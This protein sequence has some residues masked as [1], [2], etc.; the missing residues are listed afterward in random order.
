[1]ASRRAAVATANVLCGRLQLERSMWLPLLLNKLPWL[2]A[3]C[4]QYGFPGKTPPITG[5][6]ADSKYSSGV[7]GPM[8][9]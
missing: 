2:L 7:P 9:F 3:V 6:T 8:F 1:L 5:C 4:N